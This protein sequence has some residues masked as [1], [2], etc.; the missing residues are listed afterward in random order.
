[1]E[2]VT[3]FMLTNT[4]TSLSASLITLIHNARNNDKMLEGL[5]DDL[6]S[7]KTVI[8]HVEETL[9]GRDVQRMIDEGG[10]SVFVAV[11]DTFED[12]LAFVNEL[13]TLVK[14]TN[15]RT[16]LQRRLVDSTRRMHIALQVIT[17]QATFRISG[18]VEESAS[19]IANN[20]KSLEKEL[21]SLR[22]EM[23]SNND[24]SPS[25]S[26][27]VSV[28]TIATLPD[29][30]VAL[31]AAARD[32]ISQAMVVWQSQKRPKP[33]SVHTVQTQ[34]SK[35]GQMLDQSS[36][37][38][39]SNGTS[40]RGTQ[41]S[42]TAGASTRSPVDEPVVIAVC[43]MTGSGKSN[44][45]SKLTGKDVGIGHGLRSQTDQVYQSDI[46]FEGRHVTLVDTPGFAD[47]SISDTDVLKMIAGFM[48][49]SYESG[50]LLS[51][52]IYLHDITHTRVEGPSLRNIHMFQKLCGEN[53]LKNVILATT[54]WDKAKNDPEREGEFITREKELTEDF[55][56][57]MIERGS[58]VRRYWNDRGTAEDLIR[59]L[60]RH[61][62]VALDIQSELVDEH[63][64]LVDT[65]AGSFI[66]EGL[67][68]LHKKYQEELDEVLGL[69]QTSTEQARREAEKE[70]EEILEKMRITEEE[71]RLLHEQ[72]LNEM[73]QQRDRE[74]HARA[75]DARAYDKKL[76]DLQ[77]SFETQLNE[78][79]K[80]A[81]RQM[82]AYEKDIRRLQEEQSK[83][84]SDL[85]K[86]HKRDVVQ[87]RNASEARSAQ[88]KAQLAKQL[89]D[90]FERHLRDNDASS[91][92]QM[93][94]L[95]SEV[96]KL[97]IANAGRETEINRLRAAT[98]DSN[99]NNNINSG[100]TN[101][102][103]Y[104]NHLG[105]VDS[106][107]FGGA[108]GGGSIPPPPPPPQLLKV[109]PP[110]KHWLA[111]GEDERRE[112]QRRQRVYEQQL[113]AYYAKY[114]S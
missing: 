27:A 5:K 93:A 69:M 12:C 53:G 68:K 83:E 89:E 30:T 99:N 40:R 37:M 79:S 48:A 78:S 107:D 66:D 75:N 47:T 46:P 59:E 33:G 65:A 49:S 73:G 20:I 50:V 64:D 15:D 17:L 110:A 87:M 7:F 16:G 4:V 104:H 8:N 10:N 18:R 114:G 36:V 57:R 85:I 74:A 72:H 11:K 81:D 90:Q 88:E 106:G 95:E 111:R 22:A 45:I 103:T 54:M 63:K 28:S 58:Q 86:Q 100:N 1:M 56:V 19:K 101:S 97:S 26:H 76:K 60:V 84:R 14:R 25:S 71:T 67:E 62:P 82:K 77:K 24:V 23:S 35:D 2:P 44:F 112:N 32:T 92:A 38:I 70:Y 80:Q 98:Q 41:S 105:R 34:R 21:L 102:R 9:N 55:W 3:I 52:I 109:P 61:K 31:E 108:G 43:G 13:N 51:G 42:T 29:S 6:L 96:Q 113:N 91:R 94:R 39:L